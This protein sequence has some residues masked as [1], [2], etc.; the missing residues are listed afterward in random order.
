ML[1]WS[2]FVCPGAWEILECGSRH[3]RKIGAGAVSAPKP[4]AAK[5]S[6]DACGLWASGRNLL[7]KTAH[8]RVG[9]RDGLPNFVRRSRWRHND[10]RTGQPAPST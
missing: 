2:P 6:E 1:A 10:S 9:G 7:E 5:A 4:S 8:V 3:P